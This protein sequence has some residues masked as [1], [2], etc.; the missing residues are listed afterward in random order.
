LV[1]A[2]LGDFV[3]DVRQ[4]PTLATTEPAAPG[5][6]AGRNR[7][8]GMLPPS[9]FS[10]LAPHL[11]QVSLAK[12]Q[13]LQEAGEPIHDVYFPHSGLISLLAV[14]KTGDAVE[15]AVIGREGGVGLN[16][17]LGSRT[18][19]SRA[20]V[21]LPGIGLRIPAARFVAVAAESAPLRQLIACHN[22]VLLSQVQQSAACNA[23]HDV[24]AR[25]CRW[26]LQARDRLGDDRL[27]L[28]HEFLSQMLGVRRTTVSLIAHVLQASGLIHYRRG[29]ITI[30]DVSGLERTACECYGHIKRES[31]RMLRQ[32][33]A[34]AAASSSTPP[35]GG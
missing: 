13:V 25:L 32:C 31:D 22:D 29:H 17:G 14:M 23:L 5:E 9:E 27:P 4:K 30:R 26:L 16:C 1:A 6:A 18:A 11:K 8:L 33:M 28:T 15:A 34:G 24:E 20:M 21:Q 12:G 10:L 35:T 19:A 2:R 7:L 3:M